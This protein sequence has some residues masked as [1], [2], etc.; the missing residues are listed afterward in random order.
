MPLITFLG[1]IERYS[2]LYIYE[3]LQKNNFMQ[4]LLLNIYNLNI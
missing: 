2:T 3:Y 4:S 1:A